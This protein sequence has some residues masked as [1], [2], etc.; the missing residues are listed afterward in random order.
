MVDC[1]KL[2][3]LDGR[4]GALPGAISPGISRHVAPLM[5]GAHRDL[6]SSQTTTYGIAGR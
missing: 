2:R 5:S 3:V 1:T 4:C 6:L